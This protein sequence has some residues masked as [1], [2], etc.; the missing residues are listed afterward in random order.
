MR[1]VLCIGRSFL[2]RERMAKRQRPPGEGTG[3][4]GAGPDEGEDDRVPIGRND[5]EVHAAADAGERRF[6]GSG[7]R[8]IVIPGLQERFQI[9]FRKDRVHIQFEPAAED[10][11]LTGRITGILCTGPHRGEGAEEVH[12][13]ACFVHRTG[14]DLFETDAEAVVPTAGCAVD[15]RQTDRRASLLRERYLRFERIGILRRAESD[16]RHR[17]FGARGDMLY[18]CR[19]NYTGGE[20]KNQQDYH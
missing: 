11:P 10:G 17:R 19:E 9:H 4:F 8:P 14:Q 15:E 13:G 20:N 2:F 5:G 3:M 7:D 16:A 1:N 18:L 12:P 6:P